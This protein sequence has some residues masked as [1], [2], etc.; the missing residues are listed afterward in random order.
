MFNNG[1]ITDVLAW[2]S[3]DF[4]VMKNACTENLQRRKITWVWNDINKASDSAFTVNVCCFPRL[5]FANSSTACASFSLSTKRRADVMLV[6]CFYFSMLC[7]FGYYQNI[8]KWVIVLEIY[9]T[10]DVIN[11]NLVLIIMTLYRSS[12]QIFLNLRKLLSGHT[13]NFVTS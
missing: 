13:K 1:E 9:V 3:N 11:S 5:C 2:P 7:C 12:V 4:Y 10:Q 6:Y 8:I